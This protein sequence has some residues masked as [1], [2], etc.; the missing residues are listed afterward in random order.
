MAAAR[1][2]KD[3]STAARATSYHAI[4]IREKVTARDESASRDEKYAASTGESIALRISYSRSFP[5]GCPATRYTRRQSQ[6]L[7]IRGLRL[8]RLPYAAS[9]ESVLNT[10]AREEPRNSRKSGRGQGKGYIAEMITPLA[11]REVI[12]ATTIMRRTESRPMTA[13]TLQVENVTVESIPGSRPDCTLT[14]SSV[15]INS[16]IAVI[17]RDSVRRMIVVDSTLTSS[18]ARSVIAVIRRDSLRHIIVV[19]VITSR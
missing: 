12:T 19:T 5:L 6:R 13:I 2:S 15:G 3:I 17:R 11:P 8:S 9:R 14:S 1:N 16:V 18:S 10:T 7:P 4:Q